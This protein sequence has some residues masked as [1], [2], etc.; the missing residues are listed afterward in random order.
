MWKGHVSCMR[1]LPPSDVP[2]SATVTF[3]CQ[4]FYCFGWVR[5][6]LV[7]RV[8]DKSSILL[9]LYHRRIPLKL[10]SLYISII[11]CDIVMS[12]LRYYFCPL[13]LQTTGI[14]DR[15][16]KATSQVCQF[17]LLPLVHAEAIV[18]SYNYSNNAI[19]TVGPINHRSKPTMQ[20][21]MRSSNR[22]GWTRPFRPSRI[23]SAVQYIW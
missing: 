20:R 7:L 10:W 14:L 1:P 18:D 11:M 8:I 6:N 22:L 23:L 3:R 15:L 19:Q 4:L 21:H 13:M 5:N 17:R 2:T 16:E 12:C 9:D